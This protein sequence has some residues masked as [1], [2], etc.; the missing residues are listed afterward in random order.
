VTIILLEKIENRLL[1]YNLW[2]VL[3]NN[4]TKLCK[5]KAALYG[6]LNFKI[7]RFLLAIKV[8]ELSCYSLIPNREHINQVG[9]L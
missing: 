4:Y 7:L 3:Y 9:A 2:F 1:D 6:G 5:K 8:Q